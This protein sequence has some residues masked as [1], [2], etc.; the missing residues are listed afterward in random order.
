MFNFIKN[1]FKK[2]PTIQQ[3]LELAKIVSG[4]VLPIFEVVRDGNFQFSRI[5]TTEES[6]YLI[7]FISG[8]CDVI[9]QSV[10]GMSGGNASINSALIVMNSLFS[11]N[12]V[13]YFI[14]TIVEER[15]TKYIEGTYSGGDCANKFLRNDQ[16]SAYIVTLLFSERYK[17]Y[18]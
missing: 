9:T 18:I 3:E 1:V 16:T 7:G 12:Q 5:P 15:S 6:H 10:G 4:L 14:N 2:K 11:Q 8:Y 13:D 17:A